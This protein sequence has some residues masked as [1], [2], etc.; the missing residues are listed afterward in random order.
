[1]ADKETDKE[2]DKEHKKH[3][4]HKKHKE[5]NRTCVMN[6]T[7]RGHLSELVVAGLMRVSPAASPAVLL[8][9]SLART[10]AMTT[11][12][13]YYERLSVAPPKAGL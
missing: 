10:M 9:A 8:V 6:W 7:P 4:K 1:M 13:V 2:T 11:V 5:H 12:T 3:K